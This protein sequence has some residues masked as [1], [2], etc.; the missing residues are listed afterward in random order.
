M[1]EAEVLAFTQAE[2][3]EGPEAISR[4][5]RRRFGWEINTQSRYF[6]DGEETWLLAFGEGPLIVDR[7]TGNYWRT[8]SNPVAVFGDGAGQLGYAEL[9]TRALFEQWR[10]QQGGPCEGNIRHRVG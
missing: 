3:D 9:A 1:T 2:C 5:R 7:H 10:S 8:S 6:I 4:L